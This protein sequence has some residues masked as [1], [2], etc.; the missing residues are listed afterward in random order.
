MPKT[1]SHHWILIILIIVLGG[2]QS[3]KPLL[4]VD[5]LAAQ[6]QVAEAWAQPMHGVWELTWQAMPIEGMLVFEAWTTQNAGRQRFEILE[7]SSPALVGMAYANDGERATVFN[8]LEA[9]EPPFVGGAGT[10]FSPITDARAF[11][12]SALA[13]TPQSAEEAPDGYVFRFADGRILRVSLDSQ[14]NNIHKI[15]LESLDDKLTLNARSLE[16]L[17]SPPDALFIVP[18]N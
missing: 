17:T 6:Q 3:E 12:E 16:I 2:C 7:A 13:Q 5:A 8:R 15:I 18:K 9:D 1:I 11:I 4:P 14:T 10:P